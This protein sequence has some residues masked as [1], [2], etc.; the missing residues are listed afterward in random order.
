MI[1]DNDPLSGYAVIGHGNNGD[2]YT[3]VVRIVGIV[4][5]KYYAVHGLRYATDPDRP[6]CYWMDTAYAT[7]L[8][9]IKDMIAWEFYDNL[10]D[11]VR[12][13]KILKKDWKPSWMFIPTD[14]SP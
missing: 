14:P 12:R 11:A 4:G 1:D 2:P 10:T 5:D 3:A 6:D 8:V 9:R 7:R 13:V